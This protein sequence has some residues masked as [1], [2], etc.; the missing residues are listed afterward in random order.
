[1]RYC[2]PWLSQEY[3]QN[4]L[5]TFCSLF[6]RQIIFGAI[7]K[8][9][10]LTGANRSIIFYFFCYTCVISSRFCRPQTAVYRPRNLPQSTWFGCLLPQPAPKMAAKAPKTTYLCVS[11]LMLFF[12][13][14]S[15]V[16]YSVFCRVLVKC[17]NAGVRDWIRAKCGNENAGICCGS[18]GKTREPIE[19]GEFGNQQEIEPL[20]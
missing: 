5:F 15:R 2:C 3:R 9:R 8:Y 7:N 20:M 16:F 14:L 17:G 6:C 18:T 4:A 13:L 10:D 1:M 19:C 11:T 12:Q